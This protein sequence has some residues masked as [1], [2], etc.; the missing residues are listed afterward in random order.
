MLEQKIY[1]KWYPNNTHFGMH[2]FF[3]SKFTIMCVYDNL[4]SNMVFW[5]PLCI[6][7]IHFSQILDCHSQ[8]W[9]MQLESN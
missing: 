8:T 5:F 4:E 1:I 9:K 6:K 7:N 3:V 2:G